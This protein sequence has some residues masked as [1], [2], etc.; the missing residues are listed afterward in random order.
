[1]C[2]SDFHA[3]INV[4]AQLHLRCLLVGMPRPSSRIVFHVV[5]SIHI[6]LEPV[7]PE[8]LDSSLKMFFCT[9]RYFSRTR[10]CCCPI[11]AVAVSHTDSVRDKYIGPTTVKQ[12]HGF[13]LSK[14]TTEKLQDARSIYDSVSTHTADMQQLWEELRETPGIVKLDHDY[15][16][17]QELVCSGQTAVHQKLLPSLQQPHATCFGIL[18]Y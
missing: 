17:Y 12:P 2:G 9:H 15:G 6:I 11:L 8:N 4:A 7:N 10:H 18:L 13:K 14:L 1:M 3:L 16:R 5:I